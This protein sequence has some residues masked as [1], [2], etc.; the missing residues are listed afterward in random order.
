MKNAV[1]CGIIAAILFPITMI[2]LG[3]EAAARIFS[4]SVGFS[5]CV[6]VGIA[7]MF[8]RAIGLWLGQQVP[9][10]LYG[11]ITRWVA[12]LIAGTLLPLIAI[13]WDGLFL[14]L[15]FHLPR[16]D[17]LTL[18]GV[19]QTAVIAWIAMF[20]VDLLFGRLLPYSKV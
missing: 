15:G 18:F 14:G 8:G 20:I 16:L 3:G 6:M 1:Y 7:A 12:S 10:Y 4:D 9:S 13:C 2:L 17:G 11:F 5:L 19:V